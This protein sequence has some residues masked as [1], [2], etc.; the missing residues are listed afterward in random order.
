MTLDEY[1]AEIA[2]ITAGREAPPRPMTTLDTLRYIT[3]G[4]P[5]Q[6]RPSLLEL[7]KTNPYGMGSFPPQTGQGDIRSAPSNWLA[8]AVAGEARDPIRARLAEGVRG[9]GQAAGQAQDWASDPDNQQMMAEGAV[10]LGL[11]MAAP[12][13]TLLPRAVVGGGAMLY[14]MTNASKPLEGNPSTTADMN[15]IIRKFEQDGSPELSS[16]KAKLDQA[17]SDLRAADSNAQSLTGAFTTPQPGTRRPSQQM[18]DESRN[19]AADAR[20]RV[21]TAQAAHDAELSRVRDGSKERA[22]AVMTAR[23]GAAEDRDRILRDAP[24]PF[25]TQYNALRQEVPVLPDAAMLPLAAGAGMVA[26]SKALPV[27]SSWMTRALAGRIAGTTPVTP[28]AAARVTEMAA[29]NA[30]NPQVFSGKDA[31]IGAVGGVTLGALP[32]TFNGLNQTPQNPERTAADVYAA[33]L[34]DVDPRK[35]RA[36][37]QAGVIPRQNPYYTPLEPTLESL[38]LYGSKMAMGALEGAAGGKA[39]GYLMESMKPRFSGP[40]ARVNEFSDDVAADTIRGRQAQAYAGQDVADTV[41]RPPQYQPSYRPAQPGPTT[42]G[43][44]S[45]GPSVPP[46][47]GGAGPSQ[48]SQQLGG[49]SVGGTTSTSVFGPHQANQAPVPS[50][51]S[52]DRTVYGKTTDNFIENELDSVV[53]KLPASSRL[54]YLEDIASDQRWASELAQRYQAAGLPPVDPVKLVERARGTLDEMIKAERMLSAGAGFKRSVSQPALRDPVMQALTGQGHTLAVPLAV[55]G[56]AAALN[57]MMFTSD[58]RPM[59]ALGDHY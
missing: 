39:A 44:G 26:A 37:E 50:Y 21:A 36:M 48:G 59:N 22:R 24:K 40:L 47:V 57:P 3:P 43:A 42:P 17:Q 2:A 46:G 34:L 20:R 10:G 7:L 9:V 49:T 5:A 31:A 23:A 53:G 45:T 16:A 41:P 15:E 25:H 6:D 19:A 51:A 55:G 14:G 4:P 38:G 54:M 58:P 56:G 27:A 18:L 30:G 32:T 12:Y 28:Q 33:G 29:K 8:D 13:A 11:G 1:L 35:S 52:Y